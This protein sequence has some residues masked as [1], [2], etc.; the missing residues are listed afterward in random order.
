MPLLVPE[1]VDIVLEPP[2][3]VTVTV[4][5]R[6][7]PIVEVAIVPPDRGTAKPAIDQKNT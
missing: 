4:A 1:R 2:P 5:P 7:A 6:N 3:P